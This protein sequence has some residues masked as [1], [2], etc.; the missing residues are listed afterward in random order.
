MNVWTVELA[1]WRAVVPADNGAN[2]EWL[3]QFRERQADAVGDA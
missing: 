1:R 2:R 3:R